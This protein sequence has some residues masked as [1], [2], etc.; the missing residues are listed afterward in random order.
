MISVL[1]LTKNESI[2]IAECIRSCGWTDDILVF[3]S[4]S[5]DD[6]VQIA[7]AMGARVEQRRFDN[8]G[9]QRDA[10]RRAHYKY[11]WV[12]AV[13]ADERPDKELV[14]EIRG[15]ANDP[16]V[17]H[18]A[19]RLR[20]KDH[21]HGKWIKYSSLYPSWFIRIYRP[22]R[23]AY[24]PRA[25]HEYPT[26]DGSIGELNGHL[27]HDSFSK[28]LEE[29]FLKHVRYART[30]A[31]ENLKSLNE[32]N[33]SIDYFGLI[34]M[35][36][37]RRRRALKEMSFRLPCRPTLRFLYMYLFR[38]GFLDGRQGYRY[39]KMLSVYEQMIVTNMADLRFQRANKQNVP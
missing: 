12:L 30:E 10:A 15:I 11:P 19:Y 35:N 34:S 14:D 23:I 17:P 9:A 13:D 36:P 32:N 7:R 8:Y 2:N 24:E 26:V 33:R 37:V 4:F 28:G 22:D 31:M 20:R 5:D 39:A 21:F 3:D 29:W 6:T 18:V 25:V 16:N 1:I 38:M 27:L